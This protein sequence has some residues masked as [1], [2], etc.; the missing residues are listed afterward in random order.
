MQEIYL[1]P[2]DMGVSSILSLSSPKIGGQQGLISLHQSFFR[3]NSVLFYDK[4]M[5]VGL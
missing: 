3:L 5:R 4:L 2:G 1:L